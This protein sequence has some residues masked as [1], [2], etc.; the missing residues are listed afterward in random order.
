MQ[1]VMVRLILPIST[2]L[3][4]K[5]T[6]SWLQKCNPM[7]NLY[8]THNL[9][10]IGFGKA[11]MLIIHVKDHATDLSTKETTW[12]IVFFKETDIGGLENIGLR[13][14]GTLLYLVC[15]SCLVDDE[16]VVSRAARV[17]Y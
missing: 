14:H 3:A 1:Q 11:Q 7:Q 16:G 12:R 13:D 2:L 6:S 5:T 10:I 8:L 9:L 15:W 4:V 17:Y